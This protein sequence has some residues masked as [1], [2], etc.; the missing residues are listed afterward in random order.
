MRDTIIAQKQGYLGAVPRILQPRDIQSLVYS[1]ADSGPFWMSSAQKEESRHDKRLETMTDV[2]LK[3]PEM[4][5]QLSV[6]T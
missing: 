2:Q 4:I 6:T 1:Q 3:I 5:G